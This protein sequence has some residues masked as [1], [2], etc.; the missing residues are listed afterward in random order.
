MTGAEVE[1]ECKISNGQ[2][3]SSVE[4]WVEAEPDIT[5]SA[6]ENV[7]VPYGNSANLSVNVK[8][9]ENCGKVT[10][11]WLYYVPSGYRWGHW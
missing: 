2:E 3:S 4:F 10:Y 5:V 8:T 6:E 9:G 11:R 1:Y 7:W